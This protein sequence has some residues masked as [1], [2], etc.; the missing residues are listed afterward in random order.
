MTRIRVTDRRSTAWSVT[1]TKTAPYTATLGELVPVDTT[2][3][4]VTV[5]LPPATAAGMVAVRLIAGTAAV[6]IAAAGTDTIDGAAT[7]SVSLAGGTR[8]LV[9]TGAGG[10][11]TL[12]AGNPVSALDTRYAA[13]AGAAF[14]GAVAAPVIGSSGTTGAPSA[15]RFV[16]VTTGS[17][18]A[19]GTYAVGDWCITA[20]G[21]MWIC[22]AAGTP[23]S[24][25]SVRDGSY[26][27]PG[28][29]TS[30]PREMNISSAAV[31]SGTIRFTYWQ[32]RASSTVNQLSTQLGGTVASG[33]TLARM[34]V[35]S[36]ASNGDLALVAK[37][38]NDTTMYTGTSGSVYTKPTESPWAKTAGQWYASAVLV[39]ASTSPSLSGSAASTSGRWD[40]QPRI[41][42]TRG[43][44]TDLPEAIASGLL[45]ISQSRIYM[46][47]S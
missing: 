2:G 22:V 38:A 46:E 39:I 23:G 28:V 10:W 40:V 47:M 24:W 35:Y 3:G 32:A 25:I 11:Y 14:T 16:G 1:G 8:T 30:M 27:V 37:T 15:G 34:A 19:G 4:A 5:T 7:T 18:P 33:V 21:Q 26:S 42:A 44:Q 31:G 36:V 12:A 20:T 13:L 9:T 17:A 41:T 45:T 43:G 29:E 6:T